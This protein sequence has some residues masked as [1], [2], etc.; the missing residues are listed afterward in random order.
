MH[1]QLQ[2]QVQEECPNIEK[3]WR[4]AEG[5]EPSTGTKS[6]PTIR[7]LLNRMAWDITNKTQEQPLP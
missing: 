1:V 5:L 2:R 6:A 3:E 7:L 4:M